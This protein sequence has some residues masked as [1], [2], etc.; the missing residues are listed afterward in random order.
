MLETIL[1]GNKY[2]FWANC[3]FICNAIIHFA[4]K[5]LWILLKHIMKKSLKKNTADNIYRKGKLLP[6]T[7]LPRKHN[8]L[9]NIYWIC[10][11][12]GKGIILII[13]NTLN[14]N[15]YSFTSD[16]YYLVFPIVE[17]YYHCA[18][19]KINKICHVHVIAYKC[20]MFPY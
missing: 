2:Q 3:F 18:K 6:A 11:E 10:N 19:M 12:M 9:Y 1:T 5:E 8:W 7:R 14:L 20:L 4:T 17:F 15:Y 13:V 16:K